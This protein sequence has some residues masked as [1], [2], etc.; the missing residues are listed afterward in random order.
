MI[1][2]VS[3]QQK[4]NESL[5]LEEIDRRHGAQLRTLAKDLIDWS[6]TWADR[7]C[8]HQSAKRSYFC[9]CVKLSEAEVHVFYILTNGPVE[10]P[11]IDIVNL[12]GYRV[13]GVRIEFA[14]K[15]I[16]DRNS[17]ITEEN[18]DRQPEV[19]MLSILNPCFLK[20]FKERVEWLVKLIKEIELKETSPEHHGEEFIFPERPPIWTPPVIQ[21]GHSDQ[22]SVDIFAEY[23]DKK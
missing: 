13:D 23:E 8:W 14:K 11:F 16:L 17:D 19:R 15:L 2:N 10:F 22:P 9:P 12:I 3:V 5:F 4:W 6:Q 1:K 21:G 7:L 18:I 20:E